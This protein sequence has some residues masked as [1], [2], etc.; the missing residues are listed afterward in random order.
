MQLLV[1]GLNHNTAPVELRE[2]LAVKPDHSGTAANALTEIDGVHEAMF[3]AT[4]NRVECYVVS[5]TSC[6]A[7]SRVAEFLARLGN[8]DSKALSPHLFVH[9]DEDALRHLFRV[10]SSLDSMV[11]GEPQISGQVKNAYREA[12]DA[13]SI[14]TVLHRCLHQA[15]KVAKRV[16]NETGVGDHATGLA[17]LAVEL[18]RQIFGKLSGHKAL[19]VG[20]GEM[21]ALAAKHLASHGLAE[22]FITNRS[23]EKA[24]D[25]A[26]ELG[27]RAMPL[28]R[29]AN[30]LTTVDIVI[31]S[32]SAPNYVLWYDEMVGI[33]R[34]RRGRPLFL[35]DLAVPRDIEPRVHT[36]DNLYVYDVDDMQQVLS[37]NRAARQ[38]EAEVASRLVDEEVHRFAKRIQQLEVVPTIVSLRE[39]HHAVAEA[40]IERLLHKQPDLDR[41]QRHAVE[42]AF[43]GLVNKLLHAPVTNLK[44]ASERPDI[45]RYIDV[46]EE[47]Y[48]LEREDT[49]SAKVP[50]LAAKP[51]KA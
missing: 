2:R 13:G 7:E 51:I 32:T 38:R 1:V 28:E 30:L 23:P 19:L 50:S 47:L 31:S 35:I 5:K 12:D 49:S 26:D 18:A 25:L 44:R 16:R 22:L 34:A 14:Q 37:R 17:Y 9:H 3:L 6:Q 45:D 48:D 46:L 33:A 42:A 40:E 27:G 41:A 43:R 4:C 29:L 20:A 21:S 36:I 39:H 8:I 15:F 11:V 10:T 24:Q